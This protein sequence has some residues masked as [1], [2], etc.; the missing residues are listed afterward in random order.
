MVDSHATIH[1][2]T[3]KDELERYLEDYEMDVPSLDIGVVL[4]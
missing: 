3:A 4:L 2:S 1:N